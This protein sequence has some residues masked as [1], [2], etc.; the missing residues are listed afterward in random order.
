MKRA[1]TIAAACLNRSRFMEIFAFSGLG[2]R[3][4]AFEPARIESK[5]YSLTLVVPKSFYTGQSV[6]DHTR[7]VRKE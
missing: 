3:Y 4:T 2:L 7:S 6:K 1:V 5:N